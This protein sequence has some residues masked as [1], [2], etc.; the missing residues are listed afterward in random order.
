MKFL[1][2]ECLSHKLVSDL[3]AYGFPDAIHPIHVGLLGARDDK[4]LAKAFAEDRIV[5]SANAKDFRRL[6]AAMPLH[7]GAIIIGQLDRAAAWRSIAAALDFL[8]LKPDPALYVVNRVIEVA[9]GDE[10]SDYALPRGEIS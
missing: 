8:K 4:V 10:I 2:D 9:T 3:A 5:I 6:L 1:I 7:A